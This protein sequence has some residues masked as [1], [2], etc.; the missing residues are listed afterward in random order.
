MTVLHFKDHIIRKHECEILRMLVMFQSLLV[1]L[2]DD[3]VLM[4][5]QEPRLDTVPRSPKP[6]HVVPHNADG[7]GR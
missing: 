2:A 3:E 1:V 6:I 4:V 5:G 7:I